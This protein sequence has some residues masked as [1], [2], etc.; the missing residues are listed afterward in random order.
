MLNEYI[1][2]DPTYINALASMC[3]PQFKTVNPDIIKFTN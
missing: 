3:T 2:C 1:I